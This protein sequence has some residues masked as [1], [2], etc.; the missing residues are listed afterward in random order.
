MDRLDT[1]K[2]AYHVDQG[3]NVFDSVRNE[4][5]LTTQSYDIVRIKSHLAAYPSYLTVYEGMGCCSIIRKLNPDSPIE[6]LFN[7]SDDGYSPDKVAKLED[8]IKGYCHIEYPDMMHHNWTG[9]II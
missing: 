9:G 1:N 2:S 8:F 3:F 6:G 7:H 5:I 4:S